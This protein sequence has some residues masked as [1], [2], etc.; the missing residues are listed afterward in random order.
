ME[1]RE[2]N[3]QEKVIANINKILNDSGLTQSYL[4]D[5]IGVTEGNMSKLL[6]GKTKLSF[7]TL[8]KIASAFSMREIDV[9]TWPQKYLQNTVNDSPEPIEAILQI[10]LK[11][12]KKEQVLKLV[13]GENDI[14]ILNK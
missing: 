1:L 4:S 12:E 11:R 5:I 10:K 6:H 9:I 2:N 13:F 3:P 7:N 8:S 14:E